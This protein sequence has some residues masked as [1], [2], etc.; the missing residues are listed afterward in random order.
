ML[1]AAVPHG[2]TLPC[3]IQ[4]LATVVR[5]LAA[6]STMGCPWPTPESTE[7]LPK[8]ARVAALGRLGISAGLPVEGMGYN[9]A[10]RLPLVTGQN[11]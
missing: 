6:A 10:T 7:G 11:G 2:G 5:A 1:M 8:L 3:E 4:T 9:R